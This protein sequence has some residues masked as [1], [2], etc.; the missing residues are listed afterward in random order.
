[1][2]KTW[3]SF[4]VVLFIIGSVICESK[5]GVLD[6]LSI[7]K[8]SSDD[9]IYGKN[10]SDIV[11][12]NAQL[13]VY[14][15]TDMFQNHRYIAEI[16]YVLVNQHNE[17]K[18]LGS[19]SKKMGFLDAKGSNFT[20]GGDADFMKN[21]LIGLSMKTLERP[22]R[23]SGFAL[24]SDNDVYITEVMV[25]LIIDMENMTIKEWFPEW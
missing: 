9:Y 19:F 25:R 17:K 14:Y 7:R 8:L 10:W 11:K 15:K 16:Y 21:R 23:I 13:Y 12:D 6:D 18:I 5:Y 20:T 3:M 22:F 24:G 2:K 1:M 4:Y